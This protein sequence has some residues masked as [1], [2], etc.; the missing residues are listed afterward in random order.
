MSPQ[1]VMYQPKHHPPWTGTEHSPAP[2]PPAQRSS[3]WT[4]WHRRWCSG[5]CCRPGPQLRVRTAPLRWWTRR[6][7][8][9]SSSPLYPLSPP[10]LRSP[11]GRRRQSRTWCPGPGLS[12]WVWG[13]VSTAGPGNQPGTGPGSPN[14]WHGHN[15]RITGGINRLA[16]VL[17]PSHRLITGEKCVIKLTNHWNF[18]RH[19]LTLLRSHPPLEFHKMSVKLLKFRPNDALTSG[20]CDAGSFQTTNKIHVNVVSLLVYAG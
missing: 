13:A 5:G 19:R 6:R 4:S 9:C 17:A 1:S 2:A 8:G 7:W 14:L 12:L 15:T 20:W 18:S 10:P 3:R 16:R 11:G